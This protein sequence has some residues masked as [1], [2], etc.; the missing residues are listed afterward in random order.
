MKS[1]EEEKSKLATRVI[2]LGDE[3]RHL[4]QKSPQIAKFNSQVAELEEKLGAIGEHATKL[5][6]PT[7]T[8]K[9]SSRFV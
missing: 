6:A 4:S 2:E 3:V 7:V 8:A 5:V 1:L 9:K